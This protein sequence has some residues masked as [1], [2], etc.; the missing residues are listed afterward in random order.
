[1]E[2]LQ[3]HLRAYSERQA[4]KLLDLARECTD[5]KTVPC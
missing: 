4:A 2:Q 5:T 1:M 3:A